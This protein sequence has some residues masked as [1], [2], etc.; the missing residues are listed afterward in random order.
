MVQKIKDKIFNSIK[1]L[2]EPKKAV[3]TSI[4][5]DKATGL[6][7]KISRTSIY[8]A[9]LLIPVFFL[10]WTINALDFNKQALLGI[11]VFIGL[12]V[13][14]LKVLVS[15][16]L[17]INKSVFN[18]PVLILA[19]VYGI[20]AFFSLSSSSSFWGF[21]LN[22]SAG[23]IT[24]ISFILLYFLIANT[25]TS[26]D[27][28]E[29]KVFKFLFVFLFSGFLAAL[30]GLIQ[31][32][33][34]FL[35]PFD[36][37][38]L[39]SFNTIGTV[40]SLA[41]FLSVLLPLAIAF[42]FIARKVIRLLLVIFILVMTIDLIV[43]NFWVA[44][45]VLISG[46][47]ILFIF[48]MGN[49]K[50]SGRAGLVLLPMT[51]LIIALFFSTFNIGSS[52]LPQVP[53][54]A[55]PSQI[56][57]VNIA[58][59][60]FK[61]LNIQKL[62]LGTGPGTFIYNFSKFKPLELNQTAFWNV[63]FGNGASEILD[64]LITTG[65]LGLLSLLLVLGI[66][67]RVGFKYLK[68]R[69]AD[70][71]TNNSTSSMLVLGIVSSFTAVT[72]SQF[73]YPTNFSLSFVFWLLIGSLAAIEISKRKVLRLEP[74][75]FKMIGVSF[76]FVLIFISIIGLSFLWGQKYVGE[77]RY[78]QGVKAWQERELDEAVLKTLGAINLSPNVDTYWRNVSQI[79]LVQLNEFLKRTD[80]PQEDLMNQS[81]ILIANSVNSA[82]QATD[83]SPHD[84]ANWNVRGFVYR[85]TIGLLGGAEEWAIN[86]YEKAI[87]LEP[88]NP[89]IY[90]EIARVYI[91]KADLLKQQKA[92]QDEIDEAL[93]KAK[94]NL[95][96]AIELKSDYAPAHF[97]IVLIDI[98]E[99]KTQEAIDKLE[100]AKVLSPF[101]TGLAFQLGAI[102][103]NN[104]QITKART[105]FERAIRF[106]TNYSNARYFLGLIYDRQGNTD[107]A[108]KQF[109]KISELNPDNQ[110]VKDIISNLKAGKPALE[111]IQ[112]SKS[113]IEETP[114]KIEE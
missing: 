35:L 85:N 103:Y 109:R 53:I 61:D 89:Y 38:R 59:E 50:K 22:I 101:D 62:L 67:F 51:L 49:V 26:E 7:E 78:F 72:V 98:R 1:G 17:E 27:K 71:D 74:A 4:V 97:Q 69:M 47:I 33:G 5:E 94:E 15:G 19:L 54:E 11:L 55:S 86:S 110:E 64:R 41:V 79:Y 75:S 57:E 6:Y 25:L 12:L 76:V 16:K 108:M 37:A 92:S 21:P 13:W 3:E 82:K 29:S 43:I 32:F 99:G 63:R 81:Q 88:T 73:L 70:L 90:T 65:V 39:T 100:A 14:F 2:K 10:P 104:N 106:D 20:S 95:N 87:E 30:L 83:I 107:K 112:S 36:F 91:Q 105:E 28:K 114:L 23:F 96:K 102:Y 45:A 56:T 84:V 111:G 80:M 40:N 52:L 31:L 68:E 24:L 93:T 18:I 9:V 48:G 60:V 46:L 66:F 113:S 77:I 8:L 44:W 42:L 58:K 34:K